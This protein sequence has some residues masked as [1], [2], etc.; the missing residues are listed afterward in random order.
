MKE[1]ANKLRQLAARLRARRIAEDVTIT[2]IEL[3][4]DTAAIYGPM[5][6]TEITTAADP[7][8]VRRFTGRPNKSIEALRLKSCWAALERIAT[9]RYADDDAKELDALADEL[10]PREVTPME[11]YWDACETAHHHGVD[12]S[13]ARKAI[14]AHPQHRENPLRLPESLAKQ[15]T[16]NTAKKRKQKK[17]SPSAKNGAF[18]GKKNGF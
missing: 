12:Q 16:F 9:G 15:L 8:G 6:S 10:S 5:I 1:L 17:K 7:K 14:K 11:P 18:W 3:R 4:R 13:T 2:A